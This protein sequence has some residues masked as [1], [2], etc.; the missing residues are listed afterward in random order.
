MRRA[1]PEETSPDGPAA[2][3]ESP[4]ILLLIMRNLLPTRWFLCRP[5][6]AHQG[7][8]R[9]TAR[10]FS[11]N[12]PPSAPRRLTTSQWA[13]IALSPRPERHAESDGSIGFPLKILHV[14]ILR[15]DL[16]HR[17]QLPALFLEFRS[18]PHSEPE[19]GN[20]VCCETLHAA[21]FPTALDERPG[22]LLRPRTE[23]LGKDPA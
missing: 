14:R 16:G 4:I 13:G 11:E 19:E 6:I 3:G 22:P 8:T 15:K 2:H 20:W 21:L 18:P 12:P 5:L 1:A 17:P 23:P 7:G 10:P 9:T